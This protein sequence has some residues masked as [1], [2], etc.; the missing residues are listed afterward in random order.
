[1]IEF[2]Q[3][4]G[5]PRHILHRAS[6]RRPASWSHDPTDSPPAGVAVSRTT[7]HNWRKS[8]EAIQWRRRRKNRSK[9][10]FGLSLRLRMCVTSA[11]CRDQSPRAGYWSIVRVSV[12]RTRARTVNPAS[13]IFACGLRS[14]P[15][16]SSFAVIAAGQVCRIIVREAQQNSADRCDRGPANTEAKSRPRLVRLCAAEFDDLAPLFGFIGDEF[17]KICGRTLKQ[18]CSEFCE[19]CL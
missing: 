11:R 3:Y 13:L 7:A 8:A 2:F 12:P 17:S 1:M 15:G 18:R 16:G 9:K 4:P 19:P 6:V 14:H 5:F 10:T